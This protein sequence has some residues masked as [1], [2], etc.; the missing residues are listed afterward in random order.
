MQSLVWMYA[1]A[2]CLL[3]AVK[4]LLRACFGCRVL[5]NNQG[6]C[7]FRNAVPAIHGNALHV[8]NSAYVMMCSR[9]R[10]TG[11]P[12]PNVLRCLSAMSLH[13]EIRWLSTLGPYIDCTIFC[14]ALCNDTRAQGAGATLL[15]TAFESWMVTEHHSRGYPSHSLADTFRM[16]TWGIGIATIAS[17]FV[18]DVAVK[19]TGILGPFDVAIGVSA[20]SPT[21]LAD[22]RWG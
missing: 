9:P 15:A 22:I 10:S 20:C 21:Y 8:L 1:G 13:V 6:A 7:S 19:R 2:R 12:K 18:A 4:Q 11:I 14:A 3:V 16:A 5:G 17:G